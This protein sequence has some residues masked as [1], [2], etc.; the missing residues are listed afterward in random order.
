MLDDLALQA[1]EP[2]DDCKLRRIPLDS[3]TGDSRGVLPSNRARHDLVNRMTQMRMMGIQRDGERSMLL[4]PRRYGCAVKQRCRQTVTKLISHAYT[5]CGYFA[6]CPRL[7]KFGD[8]R[9]V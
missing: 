3:A 1:R 2:L 8:T 7:P 6:Q 5:E 4:H 9:H